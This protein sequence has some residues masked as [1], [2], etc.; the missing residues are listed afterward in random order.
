MIPVKPLSKMDSLWIRA[1]KSKDPDKRLRSLYRRFYLRCLDDAD[2]DVFLVSTLL[3]ICE[4][5]VPVP[6]R[7]ILND[8]NPSKFMWIEDAIPTLYWTRAK[9]C[10]VNH[11]RFIDR[12]KLPWLHLPLRFKKAA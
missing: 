3:E 7:K 9:W 2:L 10:V 4:R 12:D 6:A 8:M 5:T 1:C 11:L